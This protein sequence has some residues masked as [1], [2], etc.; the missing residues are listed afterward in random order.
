M[1]ASPRSTPLVSTVADVLRDVR[2]HYGNPSGRSRVRRIAVIGIASL[3]L[4]ILYFGIGAAQLAENF[5]A[6]VS[7]MRGNPVTTLALLF[8]GWSLLFLTVA[9]LGSFT[10]MIAGF[11]F[12]PLVGIVQAG[13]QL[14]SSLLL[15]KFL[16]P[17]E[18]ALLG[19]VKSGEVIQRFPVAFVALVRLVPILPSAVSVIAYREFAISLRHMVMGTLLAGWVRPLSLAWIGSQAK[20]INALVSAAM[21]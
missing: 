21:G 17:P 15:Y 6:F 3:A 4:V 11:V 10:V 19:D 9:P 20:E 12:G 7:L 16:P 13:S 8:V 14:F 2:E 18:R 1:S 5:E